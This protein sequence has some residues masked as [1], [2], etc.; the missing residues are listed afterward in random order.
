MANGI[1]LQNGTD[2]LLLESGGSSLITRE[3]VLAATKE[4]ATGHVVQQD[5]TSLINLVLPSVQASIQ[6]TT[7]VVTTRG[8]A[9]E[10][11]CHDDHLESANPVSTDLFTICYWA[12]LKRTFVGSAVQRAVWSLENN[13]GTAYYVHETTNSLNTIEAHDSTNGGFLFSATDLAGSGWYFVAETFNW[14]GGSPATTL[15]WQLEGAADLNSTTGNN[16]PQVTVDKMFI[17]SDSL[18]G[19][20][21]TWLGGI[22]RVR[23]WNAVLTPTELKAERDSAT[24]V[25]TANLHASYPLVPGASF[26]LDDSGNARH[27]TN[28]SGL[29]NWN[30]LDAP[31]VFVTSNTVTSGS[32]VLPN[33]SSAMTGDFAQASVGAAAGTSTAAGVGAALASGDGAAAGTSTA[34]GVG[35]AQA[36]AVG[37]SS[38]AATASA[39]GSGV[40][41]GD[42]SAAGTSAAAGEGSA[43]AAGTG[44]SAGA[45]TATAS[46]GSTAESSG[47]SAGAATASAPGGSLATGDGTSAGTSAAAAEGV[48]LGIGVGSAAGV[49]TASAQASATAEGVGASAGSSTTS[50]VGASQ[51]VAAGSSSGTGAATGVGAALATASGASAGAAAASGLGAALA[52]GVGSAAGTSSAAAEGIGGTPA[53]VAAGTSTATGVGGALASGEGSAAGSSTA[54]AVGS[55][56]GTGQGVSSSSSSA[57]GDG[58]ALA[59]GIGVAAGSST[60][61]GVA[62]SPASVGSAAGTS[63]ATAVGLYQLWGFRGL[64]TT[65][66][67]ANGTTSAIIPGQNQ[68]SAAVVARHSTKATIAS[69]GAQ[70]ADLGRVRRTEARILEE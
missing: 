10:F 32:P 49:A 34:A 62:P 8:Q 59:T 13:A 29:G 2:R 51:A 37:S 6:R 69:P 35:A 24:T 25:R 14:N 66:V 47:A 45:A 58:Q 4:D 39:V 60:V 50:G 57:V 19:Q 17:G 1:L 43:T 42:G 5:G 9:A 33:I 26:L 12:R 27:L 40:S 20:N 53:G 52:T 61:T 31:E 63:T 68:G 28:P 41:G 67:T 56:L 21:E 23:I 16:H 22:T 48:A 15:Y 3:D 55:A 7:S 64:V 38:G 30:T 54:A 18:G 44:S 11:Q 70:T 46:G 65:R 36:N